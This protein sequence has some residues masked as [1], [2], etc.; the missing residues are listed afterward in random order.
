MKTRFFGLLLLSVLVMATSC[1]RGTFCV[2]G[3]GSVVTDTRTVNDF[4]EVN[5]DIPATIYLKQDPNI[6]TPTIQLEAQANVLDEIETYVIGDKLFV[7]FDRCVLG[8]RSITGTITFKSLEQ[9]SINGSAHV[10]ADQMI[11]STDF[12]AKIN[13]S[14]NI[15]LEVQAQY[16][17]SRING[18]GNIKLHGSTQKQ[19]VHIDGSGDVR[20]F[21]LN[22]HNTEVRVNGSGKTEVR[23]QDHLKVNI[24]GSGDVY[25]K[26][27]P[28]LE[29]HV[30]GSG[31]VV[32]QN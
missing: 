24:N 7:K 25:Y 30:N 13:G 20:N 29:T 21:G 22:S 9:I 8:H 28:T 17:E 5:I 26:G 1:R 10:F 27:Y 2:D 11:N 19:E 4:N 31:K 3:S 23:V 18:S 12:T 32:S 6:S 14:G 15:E 16:I